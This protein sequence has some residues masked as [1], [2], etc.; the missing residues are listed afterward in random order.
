MT[1]L[2]K[3]IEAASGTVGDA[4]VQE[5]ELKEVMQNRNLNEADVLGA[6]EDREHLVVFGPMAL[7]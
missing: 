4:V 2:A 1:P 6:Q 7:V 5:I 3:Q